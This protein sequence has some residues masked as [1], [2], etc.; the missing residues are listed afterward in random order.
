MNKSPR[1]LKTFITAAAWSL[2]LAASAIA[3][4]KSYSHDTS[5]I[6]CV[7]DKGFLKIIIC[8]EDIVEIRYTSLDALPSKTSLV[9]TNKWVSAPQ[10][11]V[12]E[13]TNEIVL[14]TG[15]IKVKVDKGTNAVGLPM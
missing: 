5:G 11:S 14:T 3:S 1:C 12:T 10:Y 2:I 15:R 13:S 7:L 8:K 9:V 4:V 6:T